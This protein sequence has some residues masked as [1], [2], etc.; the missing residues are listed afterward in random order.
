MTS[1]PVICVL[2]L[3]LDY[4]VEFSEGEFAELSSIFSTG[5]WLVQGDRSGASHQGYG[6]HSDLHRQSSLLN[7][8]ENRRS[9]V[10][11]PP[12]PQ[13][14]VCRFVIAAPCRVA[15]HPDKPIDQYKKN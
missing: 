2:C 1:S 8:L 12:V 10:T 6:S 7:G 11:G 3:A 14:S 5:V 4:A 15:Y 13:V 9:R